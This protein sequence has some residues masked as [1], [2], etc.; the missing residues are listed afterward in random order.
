MKNGN[1]VSISYSWISSFLVIFVED[2]PFLL[3]NDFGNDCPK[4]DSKGV[5]RK[6]CS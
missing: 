3:K 5:E 1:L 4:A 6:L 2:S